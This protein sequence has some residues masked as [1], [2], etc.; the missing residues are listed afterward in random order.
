MIIYLFF[1]CGF[2]NVARGE[3]LFGLTKSTLISR[4]VS[5]SGIAGICFIFSENAIV[6]P[7]ALAGLMLWCSPAWDKYWSAA[8][9]NE[10]DLSRLWGVAM[11]GIRGMY[12]YPLFI[13]LG[14]IGYPLANAIGLASLLQG[15]PYFIGGFLKKNRSIAFAE[16]VWGVCLSAMF[17]FTLINPQ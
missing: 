15:I 6:F 3:R 7:I 13:A 10:A 12:I 14:L 5:M 11:M 1:L 8:I 16:F 2:F 17:Y 4:L 9:G